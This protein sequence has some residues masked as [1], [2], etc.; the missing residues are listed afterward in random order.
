MPVC[1]EHR[2]Q[3]HIA[4]H[5]LL[6]SM[7]AL[8]NIV[9]ETLCQEPVWGRRSIFYEAYIQIESLQWSGMYFGNA[10]VAAIGGHAVNLWFPSH[11]RLTLFV[12][13]IV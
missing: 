5:R 9:R 10:A 1:R 7:S 3:R 12:T 13:L 4:D 6:M 11:C 8:E 2:N